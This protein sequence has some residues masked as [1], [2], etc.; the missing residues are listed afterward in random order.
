MRDRAISNFYNAWCNV[1]YRCFTD[2]K[3][4]YG[5]HP[6]LLCIMQAIYCQQTCRLH[7][8]GREVTHAAAEGKAS[9]PPAPWS[10]DLLGALL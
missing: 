4:V 7:P 1:Y 10:K 9:F 5:S 6:S 8:C 3:L 2:F